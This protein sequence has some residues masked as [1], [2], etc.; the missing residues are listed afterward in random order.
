M[1]A[2]RKA[3]HMRGRGVARSEGSISNARTPMRLASSMTA[4]AREGG[5]AWLRAERS[6]GVAAGAT[7]CRMM[8]RARE[9]ACGL[10]LV[11]Y[12]L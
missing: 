6:H 4:A 9:S 5:S 3:R 8:A 7:W 10:Q 12:N 1:I 11:A 2:A